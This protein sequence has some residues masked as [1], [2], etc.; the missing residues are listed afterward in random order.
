T[1]AYHAELS[2]TV[3]SDDLVIE[4]RCDAFARMLSSRKPVGTI[5]QFRLT[6]DVDRGLAIG[7]HDVV[8]DPDGI[9]AA[10]PILHE[11]GIGKY[12]TMADLHCFRQTKLTVWVRVPGLDPSVKDQ[13]LPTLR[14]EFN[15]RGISGLPSAFVSSWRATSGEQI[16][17]RL[18]EEEAAAFEEAE[19]T[20]RLIERECPVKLTPFTRE[21]LWQAVFLGHRQNA[22]SVPVLPC[23]GSDLRDYLCG[24]TIEVSA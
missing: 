23:D 24:E 2:P 9:H 12:Q 20:F 14:R 22:T 5:I 6:A 18:I 17:R 15:R 4:N 16:V 13:F 8:R 11:G 3:F 7:R 10:A 19:K 1:R 21:E